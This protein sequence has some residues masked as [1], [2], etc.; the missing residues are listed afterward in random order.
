M[1]ARKKYFCEILLDKV[2]F[3]R[4]SVKCKNDMLFWGE[5]FTFEDLPPTETLTVCLFRENDTKKKRNKE[6]HVFVGS[7]V[8]DLLT[9][10]TNV[11]NEKWVSVYAP[12]VSPK[13]QQKTLVGGKSDKAE[14]PFIRAK[15][16][17]ETTIVLPMNAYQ[18]LHEYVKENYLMLVS[19]LEAGISLKIKDLLAQTMLK[20]FQWDDSVERFLVDVIMNE[21]SNTADE[22]LTFRGNSLA[23]KSIDTYMKLVGKNY[24]QETLGAFVSF[25]YENDEDAEV[26]PQKI[27]SLGGL[28]NNQEYLKKLL[29]DV[30]KSITGSVALF[31]PR[32]RTV[33]ALVRRRCE[34]RGVGIAKKITSASLF[35]RF[36]CPAILSPSLFQLTQEYPG[37]RVARTLTLIAKTI[38][39]LA[40]FTRFG[41]K[42]SYME[43]LNKF[44]ENEMPKMNDFLQVVSVE[45]KSGSKPDKTSATESIDLARA[46]SVLYHIIQAELPNLSKEESAKLDNL[47]PILNHIAQIHGV[48]PKTDEL[49]LSRPFATVASV[50]SKP[51]TT[52]M[53]REDTPGSAVET[54]SSTILEHNEDGTDIADCYQDTALSFNEDYVSGCSLLTHRNSPSRNLAKLN[55]GRGTIDRKKLHLSSRSTPLEHANG[56]RDGKRSKSVDNHLSSRLND[57]KGK[58]DKLFSVTSQVALSKSQSKH[59]K[60]DPSINSLKRRQ[61][62]QQQQQQQQQVQ[63]PTTPKSPLRKGGGVKDRIS[64]FSNPTSPTKSTSSPNKRIVSPI[65]KKTFFHNINNNNN[66]NKPL[67][68]QSPL[69]RPSNI[70]VPTTSSATPPGLRAPPHMNNKKPPLLK[71]KPELPKKPLGKSQSMKLTPKPT[72]Q[73]K[74]ETS[75]QM[76]LSRVKKSEPERSKLMLSSLRK[77]HNFEDGKSPDIV[78]YERSPKRNH[79]DSDV[80]CET[81]SG[82]HY[83][84]SSVTSFNTLSKQS[85]A[86]DDDTVSWSSQLQLP[87]KE[88]VDNKVSDVYSPRT[89]RHISSSSYTLD[90][91]SPKKKNDGPSQRRYSE[92]SPREMEHNSFDNNTM[93]VA[94]S[95][96]IAQITTNGFSGALYEGF[97]EQCNNS[98]SSAEY[99]SNEYSSDSY[100]T[101]EDDLDYGKFIE[102]DRME[103]IMLVHEQKMNGGNR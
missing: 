76:S 18:T 52:P 20:I 93:L 82:T 16:K 47:K 91:T 94:R 63:S 80:F 65:A 4:T 89:H 64:L 40:N 32:L 51:L 2:L 29:V 74:P 55:E 97:V 3:A 19:T 25:V 61:F 10:E 58:F 102:G 33:F 44:V 31:P 67:Q 38:Q 62:E 92:I 98:V 36:L 24:L 30:W 42:E 56:L 60:S 53:A 21:V 23:T 99:S 88:Q 12:G 45:E 70:P 1:P 78:P 43:F 59:V 100:Y 26:D 84:Q 86:A 54:P 50:C 71:G 17:Y 46:L 34:E 14:Q 77:E 15:F 75:S 7:F 90:K 13:L 5:K 11:E 22:N 79:P 68:Q 95:Q 73:T 66:N 96:E 69:N 101:S 85:C 57:S 9:M 49:R 6:K 48:S 83:D 41:S 27:T 87:L 81:G 72:L 28:S 35:L 39:N 37:E 103:D 8:I